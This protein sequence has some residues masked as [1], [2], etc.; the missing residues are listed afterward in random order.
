M[1]TGGRGTCSFFG[2]MISAVATTADP[3]TSTTVRPKKRGQ[4]R[5]QNHGIAQTVS[6]IGPVQE[7]VAQSLA[8]L[9]GKPHLGSC[10]NPTTHSLLRLGRMTRMTTP[11]RLFFCRCETDNP[12]KKSYYCRKQKNAPAVTK[13]TCTV[14]TTLLYTTCTYHNCTIKVILLLYCKANFDFVSS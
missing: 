11:K 14:P 10:E 8:Q 3:A 9:D 6:H 4:R 13:N 7:E 2:G 5:S 12:P 1:L